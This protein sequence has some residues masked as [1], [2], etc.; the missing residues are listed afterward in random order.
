MKDNKKISIVICTRN[1]KQDLTEC[2]KSIYKQTL[3][4]KDIIIVDGS[5][6]RG[7]YPEL[8]QYLLRKDIKISYIHTTKPGL[9][10]QRNLGIKNCSGDYLIFLDDDTV[11]YEDYIKEVMNVFDTYSAENIGGVTG[12]VVETRQKKPTNRIL[13]TLYQAYAKIFLLHRYGNG[14]FQISGSPAIIKSGSVNK[15]IK[16]EYL[17]GCNMAFRRSVLND[18]SFD[19]SLPG[20]H[21]G[22]LGE[23]DDVAYYMSKRYQNLYAPFAKLVHNFSPAARKGS[24]EGMKTAVEVSYYL[25]RKNVPQDLKHKT[26][27]WWATTG[28]L[29][30]EMVKG[31]IK[32]DFSG[33]RGF[34]NGWR[35]ALKQ[36]DKV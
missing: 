26:A 3:P 2:I 28:L 16:I 34:I 10:R 24:Y 5:D 25:F 4:P 6:T 31:I 17:Y 19:E 22:W 36:T 23:D 18:F 12:E 7:L 11:L 1:R 29:M 27:F 15:V 13:S 30:K 14:K 35:T 21:S 20:S 32:N 8:K 9:T 33:A